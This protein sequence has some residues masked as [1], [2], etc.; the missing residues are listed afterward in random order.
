MLIVFANKQATA[1]HIV[2][3]EFSM[4][5]D[6]LNRYVFTLQIYFDHINGSPGAEDRSAFVFIFDKADNKRV[7]S[8]ILPRARGTQ[9][10][11]YTNPVCASP[12]LVTRIINYRALVALDT[13]KYNS[14]EGYYLVWERCCRN[15]AINNIL[16]PGQTGQTFYLEF[17]ALKKS[18]K[19]FINSSP[20]LFPPLS[21][22]GCVGR[23]FRFSFAGFD[24]DG[25]SLVYELTAPLKGNSDTN[26][27]APRPKPAPYAPVDW[28]P[29][30]SASV[31][32][33]GTPSLQINRQ[34]GELTLIPDWVGLWV[35]A[36]KCIEYRNGVRIGA[37]NREFQMAVLDCPNN[38]VP[39]VRVRKPDDEP[40]DTVRNAD[41]VLIRGSVDRCLTVR[42]TTQFALGQNQKTIRVIPK[43]INFTPSTPLVSP[44]TVVLTRA[45]P[46]DSI[47]MC[48]PR[49]ESVN[50]GIPLGISLT[51]IDDGCPLGDTATISVYAL[52]EPPPS[53]KPALNILGLL[54]DSLESLPGPPYRF[55]VLGKDSL[56]EEVQ[57]EAFKGDATRP[58]QV[59]RI[60]TENTQ[61]NAII[62][63]GCEDANQGWIPYNFIVRNLPCGEIK[64]DTGTIWVKVND[65]SA[66]AETFINE[67]DLVRGDREISIKAKPGFEFN[68]NLIST[69]TTS[70]P[71]SLRLDSNSLSLGAAGLFWKDNFD[72]TKNAVNGSL[73]WKATCEDL[74]IL[75]ENFSLTATITNGLCPPLYKKSI[76][77][78]F[79]FRDTTGSFSPIPNVITPNADGFN[80]ALIWDR[81]LPPNNCNGSFISIKLYNR[82]GQEVFSSTERDKFWEGSGLPSGSYYY[83]VAFTGK[84]VKGWIELLF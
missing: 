28:Q 2:G 35:F 17:P 48:F 67:A 68:L 14:P 40:N 75:P 51:A 32:I 16:N 34:T 56:G 52:V 84:K 33:T 36:V 31:P 63:R 3:G 15:G 18:G 77:L 55:A 46:I 71:I 10:V 37:V 25:D 41:T 78:N 42:L 4:L 9:F 82:W 30:F 47:R 1:T 62:N 22:Y 24:K 65:P 13:N 74:Q 58:F 69:D 27:I 73:R 80:D 8:F 54:K 57:I 49:C 26:N 60:S 21:D 81:L 19:R 43:A 72:S 11:P 6:T 39:Q 44:S 38:Q 64:T 7:D 66:P 20:N 59:S 70:T 29:G 61:L 5:H 76:I 12:F 45:R 23:P 83:E 50:T 79:D 53:K